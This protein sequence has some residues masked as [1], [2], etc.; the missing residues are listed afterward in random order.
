MWGSKVGES[1]GHFA[2]DVHAAM[3]V[4]HSALDFARNDLGIAQIGKDHEWQMKD[5]LI[6]CL[7]RHLGEHIESISVYYR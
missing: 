3:A 7:D 5:A 1:L 4:D 2:G 6:G